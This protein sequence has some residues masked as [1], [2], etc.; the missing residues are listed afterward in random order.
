MPDYPDAANQDLLDRIPLTAR[1]VLDVGC[2]TGALGAEYLRRNPR[3]TV[4]G[5]DSNPDAAARAAERLDAVAT[6][7]VEQDPLPF[8]DVA[9]LDCVVYGDVLE[10]LRDPWAVVR[11]HA[12]VLSEDGTMVF[13][14][15]NVEHWVFVERLLRGT[16]AYEEQGLLDA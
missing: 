11:R 2:A 10:H 16:W 9:S 7:D 8:N 14:I 4:L 3:A 1:V 12:E 13:C 5:I 15:P 6:V